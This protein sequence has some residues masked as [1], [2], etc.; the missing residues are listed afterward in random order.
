MEEIKSEETV[1]LSGAIQGSVL[2]P[3]LFLIFVKD[4]TK[5]IKSNTKLFVDDAKL[6]KSISKEDDVEAVQ[7]YLEELYH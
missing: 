5:K 1:I 6:K 3:V 2:G 7:A 4:M